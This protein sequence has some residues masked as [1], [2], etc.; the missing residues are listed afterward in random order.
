LDTNELIQKLASQPAPV[1][2]LASPWRRSAIWFAISVPYAALVIL[3]YPMDF[4]L[5]Q[6][7]DVRFVIEQV[8]AMTTAAAAAIAAFASVVPGYDRRLLLLPLAPL[9]AWLAAL[10]EG[11]VQD[12]LRFGGDGLALRTDWE[13]LP[14]AALVGAVPAIAIVI[15]LRRGAPLVPH[16]TLV[17]AAVAVAGLANFAM[18]LHHYGDAS[19]IILVWHLGSVFFLALVAGLLGR[20]VL[21]W[22][23]VKSA[24]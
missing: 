12:W 16:V 3:S 11:C 19:I 20:H 23:R 14:A 6:I 1:Q 21:N 2:R 8:A 22:Q 10:G 18:R 9:A 15:M 4:N 17:L 5:W 13:C 24:P 7:T